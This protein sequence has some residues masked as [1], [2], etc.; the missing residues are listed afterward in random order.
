[1]M[2]YLLLIIA[3]FLISGVQIVVKLRLS[4]VH[5]ELPSSSDALPAFLLGAL[6]DPWL[7]LA[8][9]ALLTAAYLWYFSVSRMSLGVAFT[10]A[11]LSYPMVMAGSYVFLGEQFSGYQYAGCAL[12]IFGVWLI[13]A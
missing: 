5:G 13:A 4:A 11:S 8:G 10:F 1:M 2:N 6:R 9:I 12:I 7:W 3:V